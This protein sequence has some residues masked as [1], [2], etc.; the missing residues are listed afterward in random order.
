MNRREFLLGGAA[1]GAG[2]ALGRKVSAAASTAANSRIN[3]AVV[4]LNGLGSSTH[5]P[6]LI[7]SDE[8]QVVALCD[9]DSKVLARALEAANKAYAEKNGTSSHQGISTHGDYRELLARDDIDALLIATPDHWHVPMT[10]AAVMAG[11]DVYVEKPLS[12]FVQEGRELADIVHRH[13]G[14]VQVGSQQRSGLRFLIAQDLVRSGAL[15][16]I[17]HIDVGIPTRGGSAEP[18]KAEPVPPELNY[19]MW[20]GPVP[21]LDYDSRRVHDNFRFVPEFSG[22]DITNWGAHYLDT[23]Q[24]LLGTDYTGPVAVRGSGQ[25][26]PVGAVHTCFFDIEVDFR[27]ANGVTMRLFSGE[28]GVHVTGTK[29]SL[30]VN[31]GTLRTTPEDILRNRSREVDA[32][33]REEGG[34]RENWFACIRSRRA[35]DLRAPVEIGHRSATICHLANIAIELGRPLQWDP[36]REIFVADAHANALLNRPV[37]PEWAV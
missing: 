32:R 14:I 13:K 17:R 19:D 37:R 1:L 16:E 29:G 10:R 5:L 20:L 8:C 35:E 6:S 7:G 27:Y 11:K 4:G 15:G 25:R 23:A 30:Y 3:V 2:L 36:A 33:L 12:L 28:G 9:V 26:N 34:H 18:W 22:G 21:W 24:M 31:R